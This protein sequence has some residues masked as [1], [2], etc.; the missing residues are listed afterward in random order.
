MSL[1]G[2]VSAQILFYLKGGGR[3]GKSTLANLLRELLGGYA[4]HTGVETFTIKR[5]EPTQPISPGWQGCASSRPGE[6]NHT[7]Q[8]D[9]A[10]IKGMTGGDPITAPA[11][12]P[13][14]V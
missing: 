4:C 13:A 7:Q 6:I 2:D 14:T 11:S 8:F 12:L 9:D 10:K 1:T 3:S 5:H